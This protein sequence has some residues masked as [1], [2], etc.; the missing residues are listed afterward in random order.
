MT[1]YETDAPGAYHAE[2][3][4][5][6]VKVAP[7]TIVWDEIFFSSSLETISDKS[8]LLHLAKE[9]LP[10]SVYLEG[11]YNANDICIG[12]PSIIGKNGFEGVV[13]LDLNQKEFEMF[14]NSI[15]AVKQTNFALNGLI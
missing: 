13:E 4:R 8:L 12:V 1:K 3:P 2:V 9:V 14:N 11:E 15:D 7:P 10:C 5:S 6:F